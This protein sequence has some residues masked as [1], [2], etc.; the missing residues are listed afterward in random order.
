MKRFSALLLSSFVALLLIP[1]L[2]LGQTGKISG[3]VVEAKTEKP[4]PGANV[5]LEGT[6][7]GAATNQNGE[8]T[9]FQV[10]PGTYTVV[11]SFV[12]YQTVRRTN[13]EIASGVTKRLDFQLQ[14]A[15]FEGQEVVVRA[16][17]PL[18][19]ETATKTV[20]RIGRE[21]LSSLPTRSPETYYTIQP[22]VVQQNGEIHIRGGRANETDYLLEGLSSRS[23]LGTDNVIPVIPEAVQEVQVFAGGYA[24]DKG[25]ANSGIV[26]Q[27]L[28]TGGKKLSAMAQYEGDQLA[29][30]FSD[31]YSYGYQDATLTVGGPL[32]WDQHRFF[33]ATNYRES[34]NRQP[35][36]WDEAALNEST[37]GGLCADI[38]K[39]TCHPPVDEVAGDTASTS[40]KWGSGN[41]PG[42]GN[43]EEQWRI[44]GTLSFDFSPLR[45]R[46]SYAQVT[47]DRR[48][49][50]TPTGQ[51]FNQK[52]IPKQESTR[53][54]ASVQ[55]TYFF[56][57][58]TYLEG[59][60]GFF[61]FNTERYDP[62][63]GEPS[64]DPGAG[65]VAPYLLDVYDR[66]VVAEQL[67]ISKDSA[68][69]AQA[70]Y[71][72]YWTGQYQPPSNFRFNAFEFDRP[73]DV[74]TAYRKRTQSYWNGSLNLV[75]QRGAH[76]VKIG[77][78][79]KKWTIRNYG[80]DPGD[81]GGIVDFSSN[82]ASQAPNIPGLRDTLRNEPA[83]F[84]QAARGAGV[85]YYGY[86]AFGKQVDSGPNGPREPVIGAAW[87]NDKIEYEDIIV[88]GGLRINY[89]DPDTYVAPN[90]QDP[91]YRSANSKILIGGDNGLEKAEADITIMPRLGLSFPISEGTV[92]HLQYGQFTQ[93]PDLTNVYAGQGEWAR[94][95]SGGNF[96]SDPFAWDVDPVRTTQYE[97]G[98]GYQ[99]SEFAAF[100]LTA[101]YRRTDDQLTIVRQQTTNENFDADP[102]N[103]YKN[104]AFSITRGF[105][106][107]LRTRRIGGVMGMINYTFSDSK[108]T[109]TNANSQ[110]AAIEN[111]VA[112]P[113]QVQPLRF[114]QQQTGSVVLD[115]SS[116]SDR[117]LWAQNWNLNLLFRFSSGHPFTLSGGG[118]GQRSVDQGPLLVDSDPRNRSPREPIGA[119]QTPWTYRTDLRLEKGFDLG[120][121]S[122][123]AYI[124]VQNLLNREN[125]E[126]VYF[127]TGSAGSDGFLSSP[128]LSQ[129]VV[130]NQGQRFVDYY[131]QINLQNRSHYRESW[132]QT[133]L[134]EPRQVRVGIELTY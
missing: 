15:E 115:Y 9:I 126:N 67:G 91:P 62:L 123:T 71:T 114:Q 10:Q 36:F 63:I 109:N 133:L 52:R 116:G 78:E 50:F 97:V 107:S 48:P 108:G 101:Y 118:I 124:Y 47:L 27:K 22:S 56:N 4:L 81:A 44:N 64:E 58:N 46:A 70:R 66:E 57:E 73:G 29:D 17:E 51:F 30:T 1:G 41:F 35:I 38:S 93:M 60:V 12:G 102:Y 106:V 28:R 75:A 104:G 69:L 34:D 6:G 121:A 85:N 74:A 103:L 130:A 134:G 2:A 111:N 131:Q 16:K 80:G 127:R 61:Q 21:E 40:L 18:V 5:R 98:F 88:N 19:K 82:L 132:G 89:F 59:T 49:N 37:D 128:S 99:F 11:V 23:L 31:T 113:S 96:I 3:E 129:E 33:I 42:I 122:A 94:I 24:A 95:F 25:G 86:N 119:S 76:T 8:Y 105:E 39:P 77:G 92:F 72:Q 100:D 65:G 13:V 32:Y 14:K 117:P 26:Q 125:V 110:L 45:V 87:I 120:P 112:T 55:P 53:R 84:A 90:P 54:L 83:R 7:R 20:R 79:Y 43:P 68:S